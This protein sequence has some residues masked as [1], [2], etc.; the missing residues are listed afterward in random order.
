MNCEILASQCAIGCWLTVCLLVE[1]Q[2]GYRGVYF[3]FVISF[4]AFQVFQLHGGT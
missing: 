2:V 3:K 4:V 1:I